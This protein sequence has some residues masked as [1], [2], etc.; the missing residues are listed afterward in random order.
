MRVFALCF[1]RARTGF[2]MKLV[3]IKNKNQLVEE[4]KNVQHSHKFQYYAVLWAI[5]VP[6]SYKCASIK[7]LTGEFPSTYQTTLK[8]N[9]QHFNLAFVLVAHK[10]SNPH[11]LL[12]TA[13]L[14]TA[15]IFMACPLRRRTHK[16]TYR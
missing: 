1:L 2:F 11:S 4:K 7:R 14:C 3:R 13:D 9:E 8:L 12:H 16:Y 5:S 6:A 10:F 15:I